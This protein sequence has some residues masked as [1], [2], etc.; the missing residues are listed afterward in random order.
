MSNRSKETDAY[1]A[2]SPEFAQPILSRL[3]ELFHQAEP[4]IVET[5]KWG[6]PF[7][8]YEGMVG[9]L[10]AFKKHVTLTFW[11][12]KLMKDPE[13]LFKDVGKSNM[14]SMKI[15][16]ID[17][18]P[19]DE[20]LLRYIEEAVTLNKTGIKSPYSSKRKS[21][22]EI[23]VPDY[24]QRELGKNKK[25]QATFDGFSYTNRKEYIEWI[26]G[27]KQEATRQKRIA[28]AIEWMEEGKPRNRKY[29]KQW[30]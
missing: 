13:S 20:V 27:A 10:A 11:K 17:E 1:I 7:F 28:T 23:E 18:L 21:K 2:E 16:S 29:M 30:R 12:G 6:C 26:T 9:G 5:K 19:S 22:D 15:G 3:R 4:E 24:F 14:F 8:E 25:A